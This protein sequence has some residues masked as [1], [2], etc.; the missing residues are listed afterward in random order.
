MT[1]L[2]ID[3]AT[4]TN[5]EMLNEHSAAEDL[6]PGEQI[7]ISTFKSILCSTGLFVVKKGPS[8]EGEFLGWA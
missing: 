7:E 8:L 1:F 6:S 4:Y 3:L 5:M 2:T